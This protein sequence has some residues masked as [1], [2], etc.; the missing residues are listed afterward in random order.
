[1]GVIQK[2]GIQTSVLSYL[3]VALGYINVVLLFPKIFLPEEFGLTRVLVAVVG[4]AARFALV[5]TSNSVIRFFPKFK[6]KSQ[7]AQGL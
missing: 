2:Q 5:G 7:T 4:I 6:D 1:M 3:G